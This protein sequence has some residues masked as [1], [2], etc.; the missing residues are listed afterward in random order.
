M[1]DYDKAEIMHWLDW[2]EIVRLSREI[3]ETAGEKALYE[4]KGEHIIQ[5]CQLV[6]NNGQGIY[7]FM[8]EIEAEV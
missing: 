2:D 5:L 1:K 4:I 7:H 8:S 3:E 6:S